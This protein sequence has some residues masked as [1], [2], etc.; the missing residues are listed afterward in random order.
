MRPEINPD[1][2]K[3]I[4]LVRT[5]RIG[6]VV[7]STPVF[8]AIKKRFPNAHLAILI[9]RE[10]ADLIQGNSSIDEVILYDK[11]GKEKSILGALR[12]GWMMRRK[13]FDAAIH[14]H[15][16]A[17]TYWTSFLA[18]IPARIGYRL[19]NHWLLT[20]SIPDNKSEGKRHESDYLFDL[21]QFLDIP[22]PAH[23]EPF[24]SL[25]EPLRVS[26]E[27]KLGSLNR[28]AVFHPS[29]SCPSKI[30]SYQ[31]F[32]DVADY[33]A[34]KFQ[35][36]PVVVDGIPG[37]RHGKAMLKLMKSEAVNLCGQLQLGELAWLFKK[38]ELVV[39]NDSGPVHIASAVG[40]PVVVIYG[41]NL[42]GLCPTRWRPLG[43]K[44]WYL[45]KDVGCIQC[46][47]HLCP[48]EFK[49]LKALSA[50]E[51]IQ[52]IDKNQNEIFTHAAAR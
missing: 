49:C 8:P 5:D 28:F 51:V 47:A 15:P 32:A 10:N 27:K 39:S 44:S 1:T 31:N 42:A 46:L 11:E 52:L 48:I 6:D 4:L 50:E 19:K 16:R 30:W 24:V 37:A 14:F 36:M 25:H 9:A 18:G 41:R 20:H 21:L 45:Q 38:S 43:K 23:I 3:R 33:V 22:K 17:R 13:K 7:V 12:F 29:A 40:A 34:K 2:I 26:L 35:I